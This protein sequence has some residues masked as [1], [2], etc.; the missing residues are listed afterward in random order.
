MLS[1]VLSFLLLAHS[2]LIIAAP[3]KDKATSIGHK[4]NVGP[5]TSKLAGDSL[6]PSHSSKARPKAKYILD[7][8]YRK[9]RFDS[10]GRELTR[11]EFDEM[12]EEDP[13]L[14]EKMY[15]DAALQRKA[16]TRRLYFRSKVAKSVDPDKVSRYWK[17]AQREGYAMEDIIKGGQDKSPEA[18]AKRTRIRQ[19]LSRLRGDIDRVGT[20]GQK[21]RRRIGKSADRNT[22][23]GHDMPVEDELLQEIS[24]FRVMLRADPYDPHLLAMREHLHALVKMSMGA[25]YPIELPYLSHLQQHPS[26]AASSESRGVRPETPTINPAPAC[27]APLDI[28]HREAGHPSLAEL[29]ARP[30]EE[31]RRYLENLFE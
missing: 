27:A 26:S 2:C 22:K 11:Q 9:N 14:E 23:G 24:R 31:K 17:Q 5:S 20:S 16:I 28:N 30:Q 21:K 19:A 12:L 3:V 29:R 7:R 18:L 13:V 25:F 1:C 4:G 15:Q 8:M 10:N 6:R